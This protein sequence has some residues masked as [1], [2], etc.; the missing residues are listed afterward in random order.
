[1]SRR[2]GVV[3]V[4]VVNYKGAEDTITCLKSFADVDW[5][6][7][8][9][10][11]VV[12]DN[13]SG[14]DDV[15][16]I[17]R[18]V[19]EAVVVV[20]ETNLGFAGGC[21]LAVKKS[22]GEYVVFINNDARPDSA[23]LS[24]AIPVL[25][26]SSD[27]GA[28]ATKVLDW[29]G[30]SIDFAGAGMSWYGQ[31]F[32]KGV[33]G[34]AESGPDHETDVLF[35]TGSSLIMRAEVFE[36]VGGFDESYFM[37]FEDVDLG[38]RLWLLGYRVRY[39]PTSIS[40]HR[41]HASM[42]SIGSWREKFLLERNAL[43]TIYKNYDDENLQQ[44][45]P[46]AIALAIRRG[47]V[48]GGDDPTELDLAFGH[49]AAEGPSTTVSR[50]ALA[51]TYAVDEFVRRLPELAAE[52]ARLQGQRR[53]DDVD[54]LRLFGDA[55]QPNISDAGF[56]GAYDEVVERFS[57]RE[58]FD[59]RRRI[60]V[61]TGDTLATRMA[62]PAIRA[63]NI[64]R[65]LSTEH[66]V[67]LVTTAASSLKSAEFEIRHVNALDMVEMEAWA[68]V[69]V[70]QGFLMHEHPVLR[71]S[72]KV[73]VV[74]IYDP[75]HLEQLEQARDLGEAGRR[76]VV[77]SSTG[78]LNE[79]LA[80]GDFFMCA[81]E[82]QRDFWLGQMAALGR[83]NPIVY[84]EDETLGSLISVVPFGVSETAPVATTPMVKGVIPGIGKD[85]KVVL[86]GGGIYNWFDPLTL[87]RAIGKAKERVPEIRLLFMGV[88]HPNPAVPEMR[89]G[90]A[91]HR[92]AEDLGL[93]GKEVIFNEEWV[94]YDLRQNF[95][96]ESDIGV[97]TH[98][99]HIETAFSFRTRMLDYMWASLPIVCTAGDSLAQLVH[100]R[101]MGTV[102]PPGDVDALADALVDLLTD[103]ERAREVRANVA[104]V[105]PEYIWSLALDPLVQFCRR[106][107]RAPD[108]VGPDA[109]AMLG[110][111]VR[112]AEP[113]W[114]GVKGDVGLFREY[115]NDGGARLVASKVKSRLSRVVLRRDPS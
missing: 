71:N 75:F 3:S 31:A 21:N 54:I 96:L 83:L 45:L 94:P 98:L 30:N 80:R 72:S 12:V 10:E 106:P 65:Q 37:F 51:S 104:T 66:E 40:F 102:V 6:A 8:D 4:I 50:T 43:Y 13:A 88:K 81:S 39:V 78:V 16:R 24:E 56:V 34:P 33:G 63:W 90:V 76:E 32:K 27:V 41:H 11:L 48:L 42:S 84:D 113:T 91:A 9:L 85:D 55:L 89:M 101:D 109:P 57:I 97:S 87:I 82:K 61:A 44:F 47:V 112:V 79:Q 105:A 60:L 5:P 52:R 58:A 77:S 25:R 73:I 92:L 22:T 93:L 100:D 64:A 23:F 18:A 68:D 38:W 49:D 67:R 74:D 1:M 108:L 15:E 19:P 86:W 115:F 99:D 110:S 28:V 46:G 70:F 7:K 111:F 14:G 36:K 29:E 69:I 107:R 103:E 17:R 2:Q 59:R 20:S 53:R 114:G 62:G 26:R 95:L 35:G